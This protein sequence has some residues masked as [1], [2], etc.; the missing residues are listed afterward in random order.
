MAHRRLI[1]VL[2]LHPPQ[3][4]SALVAAVGALRHDAFETHA[5][6]V[7]KH[8][9]AVLGVYVLALEQRR[10]GLPEVPQQEGAALP[11]LQGPNI[12]GPEVQ[13]VEGADA[14]CCAA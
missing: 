9:L 6:G 7:A 5:A 14:R 4:P 8:G 10:P 12:V 3:T 11:E 2:D 1:R 13:A